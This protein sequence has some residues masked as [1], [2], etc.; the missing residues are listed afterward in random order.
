MPQAAANTPR[1]TIAAVATAAAAGAIG[2]VRLSGPACDR[3]AQR[4]CGRSLVPRQATLVD[5]RGPD[6][7]VLDQGLAL[8]FKAPS[9]Y[10]G[11]DVLEL[12]GHGGLA[13]L[14]MVL[15]ACLVCD[16]PEDSIRLAR[17][18][19]FTERAFLNDRLDLAQA[20]AVAD[21]ISAQTSRAAQAAMASLKG[22]FSEAIAALQAQLIDLRLRVEACL[23]F[24][25]EDLEFIGREQVA[26]RLAACLDRL[27]Q[28]FRAAQRGQTLREGLRV[29]LV[30]PPNVGKSSLLN[31]LAEEE[32][33]IVTPVAGTT[34]DRL[35]QDIVVSGL[36]IRLIDTAG[37][38]QTTD[39]IEQ[40]GIERSWQSVEQADLVVLLRDASGDIAADE[41]M[42]QRV[43]SLVGARGP[44]AV[45]T[46]LA[47][48]PAQVLLVLN[49]ADLAREALGAE[50]LQHGLVQ[51]Q[52]SVS[53]KT[54]EGLEALR[55]AIAEA[56]GFLQAGGSEGVFSARARQLDALGRAQAALVQA[57]AHLRLEAL[58]CLAEELR[59]A[60]QALSEI[61]GEYLPDDLLG[62]IFGHFCI[63]K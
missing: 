36:P 14:Q 47:A 53:A 22:A 50:V 58:E 61:T 23:D 51:R 21:L 45:K 43:L 40:L 6:G 62:A 26:E 16:L 10:T 29:V 59:L 31:A 55:E 9:S 18:G 8:Y 41:A 57:Q 28:I 32:V 37:L 1:Q 7:E 13:V 38:R 52:V 27:E 60:Q 35:I 5:F 34:R 42:E 49:K 33:A 20:E 63:G 12:Q 17:P 30:G 44:G 48:R 2:I 39:P 15:K 19:E 11:E 54:G 25:E 56:A 46:G 3:V 4:V 24:P